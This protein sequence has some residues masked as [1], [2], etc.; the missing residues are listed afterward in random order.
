MMNN[1]DR[2]SWLVILLTGWMDCI[3]KVITSLAKKR[4]YRLD[5]LLGFVVVTQ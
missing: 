4:G 1:I 2:L 5:F 3:G